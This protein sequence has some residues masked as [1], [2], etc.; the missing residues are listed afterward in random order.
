MSVQ[1][2]ERTENCVLLGP[3]C[4]VCLT[5]KGL[6]EGFRPVLGIPGQSP[7]GSDHKR[8]STQGPTLPFL[9]GSIQG[10]WSTSAALSHHLCPDSDPLLRAAS[11]PGRLGTVPCL[12]PPGA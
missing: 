5:Q 1:R 9:P 6:L 3:Y 12:P 11:S 10:L 8:P 4:T 2:G 7:Q